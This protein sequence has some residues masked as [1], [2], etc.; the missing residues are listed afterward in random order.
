[1][2]DEFRLQLHRPAELPPIPLMDENELEEESPAPVQDGGV[3]GSRS[4]KRG[5]N[6]GSGNGKS[7]NPSRVKTPPSSWGTPAVASG[8]RP[9][10]FTQKVEAAGGGERDDLAEQLG[11][12]VVRELASENAKL[13]EEL[14]A[15]KMG[16][17]SG[18]RS[19][20]SEVSGGSGVKMTEGKMPLSS[21]P[22]RT[23]GVMPTSPVKEIEVK[24]NRHTPGGTKVPLLLMKGWWKQS[25]LLLAGLWRNGT[26][27][28][29]KST[30][31]DSGLGTGPILQS[32]SE[33]QWLVVKIE[34]GMFQILTKL[35]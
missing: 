20:W 26:C 22:L 15:L 33:E 8:G 28:R 24:D 17:G 5:R 16:K 14:M 27:T 3:R 23:E 2:Q 11:E 21:E 31:E 18:S 4:P 30:L 34:V 35:G 7:R 10:G 6:M 12:A 29:E 19:S 32:L 1:M 9:V 13:R 25:R